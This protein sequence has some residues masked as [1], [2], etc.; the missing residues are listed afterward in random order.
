M[1]NAPDYLTSIQDAVVASFA[2]VTAFLPVLT[3]AVLILLAGWLLARFVRGAV[4]RVSDNANSL[5]D[6]L[7]DRPASPGARVSRAASAV[8]GEVA[9]W[10]VMFLA[11]AVAVR[12]TGFTAVS[13][14]LGQ[15][16]VQLPNLVIGVAIIV[17]GY[18]VSV[19]LGEQVA[20]AARAAKSSQSLILGRLAQGAVF[21]TTMIAGLGQ[22]G[23]DVTLLVALFVAAAGAISAGFAIAFGLG[24]RDFVSDLISARNIRREVKPGLAVGIGDVEGRVLEITTTHIALD[25][26]RGKTLVPARLAAAG[27]IV[28]LDFMAETEADRG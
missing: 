1:A 14:W 11:A 20:A 5:L 16:V 28:I 15:I 23:I 19:A 17:V 26:P 10:F 7:F 18:V 13:D 25:T 12:V 24:A 21:V 9:F 8:L 3:A 27:H 6:R 22:I 4:R 2:D